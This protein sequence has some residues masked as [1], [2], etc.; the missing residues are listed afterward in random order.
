MDTFQDWVHEA[1]IDFEE[2]LSRALKPEEIDF[3]KWVETQFVHT[4]ANK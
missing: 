4:Q 1:R 3:L 2:K